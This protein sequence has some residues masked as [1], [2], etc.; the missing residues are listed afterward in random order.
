M[1]IA[2][3]LKG[4]EIVHVRELIR[5]VESRNPP[6]SAELLELSD[7]TIDCIYYEACDDPDNRLIVGVAQKKGGTKFKTTQ[8]Y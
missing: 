6:S 1:P 2:T 8:L 4:K 3:T 5:A 7:Q